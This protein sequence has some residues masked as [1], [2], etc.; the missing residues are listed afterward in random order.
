[1]P[2]L[3]IKFL[4]ELPQL[5]RLFHYYVSLFNETYR[6]RENIAY[7]ETIANGML[8]ILPDL[9]T[10]QRIANSVIDSS[11]I[12]KQLRKNA[13]IRQETGQQITDQFGFTETDIISINLEIFNFPGEKVYPLIRKIFT[14][15]SPNI[16][17]GP[18]EG[19][20]FTITYQT[21]NAFIDYCTI[22]MLNIRSKM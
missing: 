1:M 20:T 12:Q 13:A 2:E 18:L 14:T 8:Y 4:C 15:I 10:Y 6:N 5:E 19:Q 11:T 3:I 21:L 22:F 17:F 7:F 9:E 16:E